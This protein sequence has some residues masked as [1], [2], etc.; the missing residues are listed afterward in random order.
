M[1]DYK[2]LYNTH[3]TISIFIILAM[4]LSVMFG[5]SSIAT[6][7]SAACSWFAIIVGMGFFI[8]SIHKSNELWTE[9]KMEKEVQSRLK[10]DR[11]AKT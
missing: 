6:G 11:K 7:F 5:A 10:A 2:K 3:L 4:V 9:E 8:Y 1:K